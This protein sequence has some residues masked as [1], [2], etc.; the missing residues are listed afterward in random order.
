MRR[1][2]TRSQRAR[3][4]AHASR[5]LVLRP[6][7][8]FS[9]SSLLHRGASAARRVSA[10][11]DCAPWRARASAPADD[12]SLGGLQLRR[13]GAARLHG[14]Q[15]GGG[16]LAAAHVSG[17]CPS[18]AKPQ[19]RARRALARR[20]RLRTHRSRVRSS[21]ASSSALL[22]SGTSAASVASAAGS[23]A[24]IV[25]LGRG[26]RR[27]GGRRGARCGRAAACD[28]AGRQAGGRS[29]AGAT[30]RRRPRVRTPSTR[31]TV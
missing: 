26:H 11:V 4:S 23:G 7:V 28:Q 12:G 16:V 27:G 30:G 19:H 15:E 29:A 1:F 9:C 20:R 21:Y 2:L 13:F 25:P 24:G 3:C 22:A 31:E 18:G 8:S 14:R 6:P 10:C 17:A 5:T